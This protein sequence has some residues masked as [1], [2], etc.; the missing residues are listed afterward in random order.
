MK[1]SINATEFVN[2]LSD[3]II[4][5]ASVTEIFY[6]R[7]PNIEKDDYK[8]TKSSLSI[9]AASALTVMDHSIQDIILSYLYVRYPFLRV[10]AEENTLF[11]DQFNLNNNS[12][13]CVIID[14]IDGTMHYTQG[15]GPYSIAVGLTCNGLMEA[16]LI[17]RPREKL[18]FSAVK[19]K[20]AFCC[21]FGEK[22]QRLNIDANKVPLQCY[23]SDKILHN[24]SNKK[25]IVEEFSPLE[26]GIKGASFWMTELA[27][28]KINF[29]ITTNAKIYDIAPGSLIIEEA[30]GFCSTSFQKIQ[31]PKYDENDHEQFV[32]FIDKASFDKVI[33]YFGR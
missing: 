17:A 7:L 31:S 2:Y 3:V 26:K 15:D 13:Y 21:N 8:N 27:A 18:L 5:C 23:I 30:G 10:I 19:G 28:G 25:L 6:G 16:S 33:N 22:K 11:R 4:D 9:K 29:Y 24:N 1:E 14:A 12:E 32:A 20:G